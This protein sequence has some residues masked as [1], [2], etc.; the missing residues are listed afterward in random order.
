MNISLLRATQEDSESKSI[1]TGL[2]LARS[3]LRH[4]KV[5]PLDNEVY[6]LEDIFEPFT[7]QQVDL[8]RKETEA[9][10][11]EFN[12]TSS[13]N[14]VKIQDLPFSKIMFNR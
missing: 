10:D 13:S 11:K 14:A 7:N 5:K 9:I 2:C 12:M 1:G 4:L 6:L 8:L 3:I